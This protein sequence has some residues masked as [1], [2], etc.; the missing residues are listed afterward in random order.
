MNGA[1]GGV[2]TRQPPPDL[3]EALRRAGYIHPAQ[4]VTFTAR[5]VCG[6]DVTWTAARTDR[7]T[8]TVPA[9]CDCAGHLEE[10]S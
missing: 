1:T 8:R 9:A 3:V 4:T 7:T 5:C 2:L 6:T 10:A